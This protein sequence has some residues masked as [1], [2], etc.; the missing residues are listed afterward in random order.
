MSETFSR[1]E[2]LKLGA[3]T[4][5]GLMLGACGPGAEGGADTTSVL[6]EWTYLGKGVAKFWQ[7]VQDQLKSQGKG[8]RIGQLTGVPFESLYQTTATQMKARSG[9]D[10]FAYFPDYHAFKLMDDGAITSVDELVASD[11]ASHWLLASAKFRDKQWGSPLTLEIAVLVINRKL[12]EKAGVQVDKEFESYDAFIEACEKLT[13]AGITPIQMSSADGLGTDK[14]KM[15]FMFQVCNSPVELLKGIAGDSDLDAPVFDFWIKELISFRDKYMS[16]NAQH[17][18]E[19]VAVSKFLRGEA[20]MMLMYTGPVFAPNVGSEFEVVGFPKAD[21]RFSRPAIGSGDIMVITD[22]AENSEVAGQVSDYIHE[23]EQSKLWWD[24]TASLPADDRFDASV[25]PRE[26]RSTWNLV[27]ERK[28]DVY[29]LWWPNNFFPTD[30]VPYYFGLPQEIMTGLTVEEARSKAEQ[31]FDSFREQ[32][33]EEV[34]R[35]K[36][37]IPVFEGITG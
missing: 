23:P 28:E 2:A 13:R 25:L 34:D 32:N 3:A 7:Q 17:E 14:W 37:A 10:M 26:A 30:F 11:E 6:Y 12:L 9:A 35:V 27:L 36:K 29:S 20:G 33:P 19:Q 8:P 22:Y 5:V 24:L 16:E 1:R 15:L 18:T 31:I 4:G 21:A